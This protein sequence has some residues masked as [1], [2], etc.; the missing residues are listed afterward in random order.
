M[1][2]KSLRTVVIC[3]QR[4]PLGWEYLLQLME[5][6]FVRHEV[7]F[8]DCPKQKETMLKVVSVWFK[9]GSPNG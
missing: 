5:G 1:G 4:C 7:S 8:V 3:R 6:H 9:K 2:K